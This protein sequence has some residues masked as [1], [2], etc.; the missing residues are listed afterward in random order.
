MEIST[1]KQEDAPFLQELF[2]ECFGYPMSSQLWQWKYA[3]NLG[4]NLIFKNDSQLVAHYGGMQRNIRFFGEKQKAIQ[5]G[6]VMV[7]KRE[8]AVLKKK[9]LYFQI[10]AE[11]LERYI[12]YETE[13]LLGFGFPTPTALK[14]ACRLGLYAMVDEMVALEYAAIKTRPSIKFHLQEV[15][16]NQADKYA[17]EINLLWSQMRQ[18]YQQDIIVERDWAYI[19]YRYFQ[20]PLNQYKIFLITSRLTQ[21]VLG[22]LVLKYQQDRQCWFL[23]DYVVTRKYLEVLFFQAARIIARL[24]A[25]SFTFWITQSHVEH[26]PSNWQKRQQANISIPT[27]IWHK[28]PA[29]KELE[30]KWWLTAGDTDFL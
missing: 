27:N 3:N 26:L 4:R 10:T 11:F 8:R 16:L 21:K 25:E 19:K 7:A 22:L 5:I 2:R 29:T 15:S 20:H 6:D 9:G 24:G 13:H 23:L 30:G 14:L 17:G 18:E 28:G 1:A 12:G